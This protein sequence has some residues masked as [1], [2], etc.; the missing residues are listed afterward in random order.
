[1]SDTIPSIRISSSAPPPQTSLE[2]N[3]KRKARK[4]PGIAPY[5]FYDMEFCPVR[6][7]YA[8]LGGKWSLLILSHLNFGTHRFSELLG[9]IPDISQRM[10]TQTLRALERDG[11]LIREARATVPPRVDYT[12]TPL[13]RNFLEKMEIILQWS[14][15]NRDKIEANRHRHDKKSMSQRDT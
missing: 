1:M 2:T 6:S 5:I 14:L 8:S 10:L 4:C 11:M 9:A 12:I 13:G 15:L 3:I 7:I